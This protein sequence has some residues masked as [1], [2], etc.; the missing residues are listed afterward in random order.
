MHIYK[1][2]KKYAN[3]TRNRRVMSLG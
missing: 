3:N 2:L 1:S